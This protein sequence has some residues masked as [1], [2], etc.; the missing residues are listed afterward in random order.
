[1]I[2]NLYPDTAG[3]CS[4]LPLE[5]GGVVDPKLK[6]YGTTNIRV[7]DISIIPLH[8][9][10]HLQ[11]KSISM[12]TRGAHIHSYALQPLHMQLAR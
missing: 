7:A 6:V 4:M 10:A 12:L 9:S 11:G 8:I 2:S 1:M 5:D 3:S